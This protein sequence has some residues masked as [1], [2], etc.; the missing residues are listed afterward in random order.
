MNKTELLQKISTA[1]WSDIEFKEAS[2]DL[3]KSI[4]ATVSAFSNSD[5]GYIVLGVKETAKDRFIPVGVE[6]IDKIQNDF[7]TTL[8]SN[9]FN[10]Q[11]SSKGE[12]I[13]IEGKKLLIFKIPPMPRQA[14]P[15]YFNND[16][17]NTY[18]RLGSTDQHCSKEEIGRMLREASDQTSDSMI[19]HDYD[20][21]HVDFETVAGYRRYL[22]LR[23]PN[24]D[25]IKLSV[26]DFLIKMGLLKNSQLTVG[27]LLLFGKEDSISS[28]FPTAELSVYQMP[29]DIDSETRWLDRKIYSKN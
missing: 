10:I 2:K 12:I 14:K 9:K 1:E 3:P 16:I 4:W 23:D 27:G 19:L 24:H 7:I 29:D 15:V 26:E 20:I 11:L 22:E 6:S 25:F 17:R 5:G 18:I 8:R 13:E 21:K 28:R